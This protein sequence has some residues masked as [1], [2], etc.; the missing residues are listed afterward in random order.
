MP[1][2][3]LDYLYGNSQRADQEPGADIHERLEVSVTE[4]EE[5]KTR[6]QWLSRSASDR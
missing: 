3:Q 5:H 6:L 2:D 1:R 4:L